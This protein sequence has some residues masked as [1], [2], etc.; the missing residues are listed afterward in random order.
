[1]RTL[2]WK[3]RQLR[4]CQGLTLAE[5][6]KKAN[7][8]GNPL[9]AMKYGVAI[10]QEG[11]RWQS[12]VIEASPALLTQVAHAYGVVPR[13][14]ERWLEEESEWRMC[15]HDGNPETLPR[16]SQFIYRPLPEA[17]HNLF[18]SGFVVLDFE[19]TG[20]LAHQGTKICEATI[21]NTDGDPILSSLI[22]PGIHIPD[23]L[24]AEVHGISDEMVKD[25]PTFREIY[26]QIASAIQGKVVIA[27]NANYDC[28]LL[29][30]LIIES[31]LDMPDFEQWCLM[32]AYKTHIKSERWVRLG[33]ACEREGV[34]S[35]GEAHRSLAD[36]IST[37]RLL[38]KLA[39]QYGQ[40]EESA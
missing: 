30:R 39:M 6:A 3:L 21:L 15:A 17:A 1:M 2:Q 33:A 38:Q 22:N 25:A 34:E 36:T 10:E 23:D 40:L 18:N 7:L 4:G 29:D 8:S 24:T 35:D 28:Y 9:T 20:A 12:D 11:R 26:P 16:M 32:E 19:T 13:L 14:M 37:W 27:Y 31:G 5:C